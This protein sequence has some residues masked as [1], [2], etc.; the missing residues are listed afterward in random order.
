MSLNI[1]AAPFQEM[2]TNFSKTIS[3]T[4]VTVTN[5][6]LSGSETFSDGTPANISGAFFRKEDEYFHKNFGELQNADAVLMVLPSV[7][8]NKNDK[9]TYDS[10]D[11][12]VEKVVTRRIE[13]VSFYKIAQCFKI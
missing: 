8:I 9:L 6:N 2:I 13:T 12:R 5:S 3:R 11:Y 7:T 10:E 4:P 1:T